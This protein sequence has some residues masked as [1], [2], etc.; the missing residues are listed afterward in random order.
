MADIDQDWYYQPLTLDCADGFIMDPLDASPDDANG[1]GID[2]SL[3]GEDLQPLNMSGCDVYLEWQTKK[4]VGIAEFEKVDS[5]QGRWRIAYPASMLQPG[6]AFCRIGVYVGTQQVIT[7]KRFSVKV[8]PNVITMDRALKDNDFSC[9]AQAVIDLHELDNQMRTQARR[10]AAAE[11]AREAR[12]ASDMES[13]E[14]RY[15]EA[16]AKRDEAYGAAEAA[17]DDLYTEAEASREVGYR[18]AED[19]RD[20]AYARSELARDA[21]YG[22]TEQKRTAEF[23][24]RIRS[25]A[26]Q[27]NTI[28]NETADRLVQEVA[29][30]YEAE[31]A[32]LRLMA[33]DNAA[34]IAS[35]HGAFRIFGHTL[36]A[37]SA[38]ANIDGTTLALTDGAALDGSVLALQG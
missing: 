11:D 18:D 23:D 1:R 24:E 32:A 20:A 29:A 25:W 13:W 4:G 12:F 2:L 34:E 22:T 9:F 36:I 7:S 33:E 6:L 35:Y 28:Y 15:A 10:Y 19:K 21:A 5:S 26:D 14:S 30:A 3:V 31:I 16:E 38:K 8:E 27:A 17:R 37:P